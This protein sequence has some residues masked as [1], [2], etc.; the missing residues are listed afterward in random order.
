MTD[1]LAIQVL[2]KA[3]LTLQQV[4]GEVGVSKRSVQEI[5]KEPPITVSGGAAT[6]KCRGVGRPSQVEAFRAAVAA[7]LAEE[8]S[9]PTVEV[10][11]RLR[12]RG[13][14][15]QKSALYALVR[16]LRAKPKPEPPLVLFE[17]L[18]G[19]FSQHDFGQVDVSY[20]DGSRERVHF[21]V[22]RLKFSRW[23]HVVLVP[24][25]KV[26]ALVRAL[27]AGF[28]AF[29]GVPV[30]SVFDNPKTIVVSRAGGRPKWNPTFAEAVLDYG[31]IPELCTPGQPRQ[32]GSVENGV[33]WVKGS[34]FKVRRFHDREDLRAQLAAW[35]VEVNTERPSRATGV[36]PAARIG[37]ERERLRPLAIPPADYAL[38]IP[39]TVR[40][41]GLVEH[42]G[43]RYSMPPAAAGIPGTLFLGPDRVRILTTNGLQAEHPRTPEA[44]TASYRAEDRAA[45]L[46]AVHGARGRL[47]LQRQDIFE[48]GPPGA[49]LI[50]EWVHGGRYSW[51][52]QVEALHPLLALHGP[53]RVL[54]AIERALADHRCH[55]DAIA[56]LLDHPSSLGNNNSPS[57]SSEG[58]A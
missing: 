49:A 23:T 57:S 51:K 4:A 2:R 50:T 29:G 35:L 55:A 11:H 48:L 40:T 45:R 13:Y 46:A 26:E 8:P 1:R 14:A 19:E 56:W 34:F 42:A 12:V 3:G 52:N 25:E 41:T 24:D 39:V 15:G 30:R 21:F 9:L 47:Y 38:R 54:A 58:L 31:F 7:V 5:L 6:P 44:G 53:G 32:K 36:P 27:L 18:A 33:G 28:E 10:L 16:R 20:A 22:S 17:G 37:A 43:I